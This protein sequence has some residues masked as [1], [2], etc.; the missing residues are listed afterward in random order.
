MKVNIT[1]MIIITR[2][3]TGSA[4]VGAIFCCQNIVA[5]ISSG[6]M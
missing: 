2:C 1:G 5:P 4:E 6:V 3:W